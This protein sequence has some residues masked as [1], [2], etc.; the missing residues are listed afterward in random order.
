LRYIT[1]SW[2]G[3]LG[4]NTLAYWAPSY[5][6][7]EVLLFQNLLMV[8]LVSLRTEAEQENV[9]SVG[10]LFFLFFNEK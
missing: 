1:L 4:T 2:K 10:A 8:R 6:E 7:N 5:E 9:P 3:L